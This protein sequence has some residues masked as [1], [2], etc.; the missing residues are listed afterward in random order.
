MT[1]LPNRL[2]SLLNACL[3][4]LNN[5][6]LSKNGENTTPSHKFQL[7]TLRLIWNLLK[8]FSDCEKKLVV[9]VCV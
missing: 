5:Q 8:N 1:E 2:K 9:S 6:T 4:T 3:K 7:E